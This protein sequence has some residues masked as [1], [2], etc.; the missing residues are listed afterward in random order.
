MYCNVLVQARA[1]ETELS[2]PP[3]SLGPGANYH[4]L[5][6]AF[7]LLLFYNLLISKLNLHE[8]TFRFTYVLYCQAQGQGQGQ[9]Q[10][11]NVKRQ[12]SKLDPEVGSVMG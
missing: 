11:S 12:T 7:K 5:R 10:T 3:V 6:E 2:W 9:R 4:K 1:G 8:C